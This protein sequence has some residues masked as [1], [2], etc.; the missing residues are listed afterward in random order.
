MFGSDHIF[1]NHNFATLLYYPNYGLLLICWSSLYK[2]SKPDSQGSLEKNC[3][4]FMETCTFY[5]KIY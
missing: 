1:L 5:G 3:V 2:A 4:T